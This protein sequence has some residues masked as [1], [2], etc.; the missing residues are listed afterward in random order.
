MQR[1][2]IGFHIY[3]Y[4]AL[5]FVLAHIGLGRLLPGIQ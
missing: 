4:I 3:L 2:D 5:A 1:N